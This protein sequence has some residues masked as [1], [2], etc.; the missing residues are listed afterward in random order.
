[1][2][3]SKGQVIGINVGYGDDTHSYAIPSGALKELLSQSES[4][5]LLKGWRKR[6]HI[7]AEVHHSQDVAKFA[8]E[9]YKNAIVDF[10]KAIELNPEHVRAYYKRVKAKYHINDYAGAIDD[11]THAIK[12]NPEQAARAYSIRGVAKIKLGDSKLNNGDEEKA[13]YLY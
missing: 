4:L 12:L 13:R 7:R 11:C 8:A 2:L 10:D 6:N 3:N 5:E 1:M 9:G